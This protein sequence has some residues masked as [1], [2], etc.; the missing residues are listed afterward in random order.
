MFL[1]GALIRAA[2]AEALNVSAEV[3]GADSR[4]APVVVMTPRSGWF[5]CASERAAALAAFVE[6]FRTSVALSGDFYLFLRT[7]KLIFDGALKQI[8][9]FA[10]PKGC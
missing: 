7:R 2:K 4:L 9:Y 6:I 8:R 5:A 1:F 10:L 3:P